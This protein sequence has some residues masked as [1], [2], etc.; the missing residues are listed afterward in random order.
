MRE[1]DKVIGYENIKEELYRIIEILRNSKKYEKLGV[2]IPR[3][4]LL[5]GSPGIAPIALVFP[6][7]VLMV[8]PFP[9]NSYPLIVD[10]W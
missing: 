2:V 10:P 3:G 5:E 4:L 6:D 1:L 8:S 9:W 7:A